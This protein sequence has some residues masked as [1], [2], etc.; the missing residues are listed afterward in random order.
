MVTT[1]I[2]SCIGAVVL[3]AVVMCGIIYQGTEPLVDKH[4]VGIKRTVTVRFLFAWYDLWVGVFIDRKG[5]RIYI[6]PLPMIGIVIQFPP[7]P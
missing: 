4:I 1:I 3:F 7:R 6:F 5:K 2:L